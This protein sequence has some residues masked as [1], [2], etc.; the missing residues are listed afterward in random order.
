MAKVTAVIHNKQCIDR[1]YKVILI[2]EDCT[3]VW[4]FYKDEKEIVINLL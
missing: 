1:S 2:K 3:H 4:L